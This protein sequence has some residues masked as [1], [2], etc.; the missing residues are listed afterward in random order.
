MDWS[1]M[2]PEQLAQIPAGVPPRGVIPNLVN[3][4]NAGNYV[5]IANS[6]FVAMMITFVALRFYVVLKIKK[7]MGADDWMVVVS[8]IGICY[9]FVVVCLAIRV[10]KFGTHMYNL[11]VLHFRTRD[12]AL[13]MQ[14]GFLTNGPPHLIW[15]WVKTTFFLMYLQL[16]RPLTWLRR[17]VYFGLAVVWVWYVAM[18]IAQISI[19]APPRG[20]GWVESFAT[21]RYLQTF[22]ICVPTAYFGLA[23]DLYIMVLPLVAISHLRLSR[24]KRIGVAAMFTTGF[25]CCVA[26]TVSIYFQTRL[27]ENAND[28]TFYVVFIYLAYTLEVCVAISISCMPSLARLHKDKTGAKVNSVAASLGFPFRSFPR[29]DPTLECTPK[30]AHPQPWRMVPY[31]DRNFTRRA[32]PNANLHP[33]Q[34]RRTISH[35]QRKGFA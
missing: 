2:S 32:S 26:S 20:H 33:L 30:R 3:P 22:K 12:V 6:I 13:A 21:P 14:I 10:A 28:F 11:S 35:Y 15:P 34:I 19:T 25:T 31:L 9:Y 8:V 23:S 1:K 4:P 29:K 16:F 27:Y 18:C 7:K 17:C 5:I 24:L